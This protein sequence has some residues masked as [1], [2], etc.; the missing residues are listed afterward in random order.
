[1]KIAKDLLFVFLFLVAFS[2]VTVTLAAWPQNDWIALGSLIGFGVGAT[3]LL[4]W[5]QDRFRHEFFFEPALRRRPLLVFTALMVIW[6]IAFIAM[7][8]IM[9][10][11][12]EQTVGHPFRA[13][14]TAGFW[15]Y[16]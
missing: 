10:V 2:A 14:F 1:M 12:Y 7:I 9:V 15:N 11:L 16:F 13:E 5:S 4:A 6:F 8:N 3:R